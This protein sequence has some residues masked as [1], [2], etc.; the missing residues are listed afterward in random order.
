[1]P[2][3]HGR[4]HFWHYL[5]F[6]YLW[7][8]A[9]VTLELSVFSLLGAIVFGAVLAECRLSRFWPVRAVASTYIYIIRGTPLLL[10]LVLHLRRA[11]SIG[12]TLSP[13]RRRCW[14]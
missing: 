9:V 5:T 10:Q 7:R 13:S 8:G 6:G 1:M 3:G 14:G 11:A 12:I 2:G 4:E